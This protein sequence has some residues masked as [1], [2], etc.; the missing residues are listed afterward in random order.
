MLTKARRWLHKPMNILK[1]IDFHFLKKWIVW[2]M[3]YISIKLFQQIKKVVTFGGRTGVEME[4]GYMGFQ[5]GWQ[6]PVSFFFS[7]LFFGPAHSMQNSPGQALNTYHS[8]NQSHSTDNA[9]SLT[10]RPPGNSQ[11]PISWL[12]WWFQ[13]CSL[14]EFPSWL[15][16]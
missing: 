13:R 5:G 7:F 10:T 14:W 12:E 11:G 8:S 16:G 1:N 9:R 6:S 3:N 15:K 4:V 2:Y